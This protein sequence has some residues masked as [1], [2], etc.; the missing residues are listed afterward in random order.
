LLG[1]LGNYPHG[2][3]NRLLPDS[4]Y[5]RREQAVINPM[6]LHQIKHFIAVVETGGFTK[7]AQ[8]AAVSQPAISASIAKLEAELDVKLLDRRSSPV[9]PTA[10]GA[11]LLEAGKNILQT[12]NAVKAEL[13]TIAKRK[14]LRIGILQSLFSGRVSR[15]LSAFRETNPHVPVEVGDGGWDQLFGCLASNELDAVLTIFNGIE[16]QFA[17]R[18]LFKMPYVLA[19]RE[20]H[21]FA[22]RQAV[23]LSDL[24]N[25]PFILSKRCAFLEDVTNALVSPGI[26]IRVVCRTGCCD[27]RALAL[28][29][30]GIGL[31]LVPTHFE[32]PGVKQVPVSDLGISRAIGLLWSR[33]REVG[34]L[35]EFIKFAESQC[36]AA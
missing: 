3:D 27:D 35:K 13:K 6:E 31:A 8:R 4:D 32:I 15:L 21:P 28:V 23:N 30:A 1:R 10:A 2:A 24:D 14:L 36:W 26:R 33:E 12:C 9:V 20:D 34:D 25:E 17:S 5:D 18:V 29:A 19:V 7:G 11:R 16:S 22:Y